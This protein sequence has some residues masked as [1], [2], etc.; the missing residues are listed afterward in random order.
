MRRMMLT[1]LALGLTAYGQPATS[2]PSS[3]RFANYLSASV[4]PSAEV[5]TA[6][7]S[8]KLNG[9][10]V[11]KNLKYG[12]YTPYLHLPSRTVT[13]EVDVGKSQPIIRT[14]RHVPAGE[15]TAYVSGNPAGVFVSIYSDKPPFIFKDT[16]RAYFRFINLYN[17]STYKDGAFIS[18][19]LERPC[20]SSEPSSPV[21]L[22]RVSYLGRPVTASYA[23]S[24]QSPSRRGGEYWLLAGPDARPDA[25]SSSTFCVAVNEEDVLGKLTTVLLVYN[26]FTN[27][28]G[29]IVIVKD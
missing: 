7:K 12:E 16:G 21:P 1:L 25:A 5:G 23:L 24:D 29:R 4:L 2:T 20:L 19:S 22:T 10:I 6:I 3:V 14:I 27:E 8:I 9:K 13:V 11:S 26:G 15:G 18:T 17:Y 28:G